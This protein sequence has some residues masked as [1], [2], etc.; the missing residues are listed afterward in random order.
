MAN[1]GEPITLKT[2]RAM[3]RA[4]APLS[5]H[6]LDYR[7]RRGK[8]IVS[9]LGERKGFAGVIR[10]KGK[11]VWIHAASVGEAAS[12][13]PLASRLLH[14]GKTDHV[15]LTTGT[16]TSARLVENRAVPG[17]IHQFS[18]LDIPKYVERFLGHWNPELAIFVESEL[19][20]NM[21]SGLREAGITTVLINGRLSENSAKRWTQV[22]STIKY[23]LHTFARFLVQTQS[24]ADRLEKLGADHVIVSGNLKYDSP[25]PSADPVQLQSLRSALNRRPIWAAIST[26]PGE[27]E[28]VADANE[29]AGRKIQ[30]L[31]SVIIP[32]HP[33]RGEQIARLLT[34]RGFSVC[35]RSEGILPD[36]KTDIYIADTLGEIGLFCR[37]ARLVFVGG[38]LVPHGGQ[39]PIEPIKLGAAVLHG[40][41]THNFTEIYDILAKSGALFVVTDPVEMAQG[42]VQLFQ[43]EKI[44]DDMVAQGREVIAGLTGALDRTLQTISPYLLEKG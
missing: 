34:D 37:L 44:R 39:N 17:I 11:M 23:L 13:L 35:R 28:L 9:R 31:L 32:R 1:A 19:W 29:I 24:D 26:H 41:H 38:S 14:D 33:E 5:S 2:Y 8:E 30:G 36:Q 15:L 21:L 22:P 6:L 7:V 25:P 20:P 27:D 42:V 18:P 4:L 40:P 12:V 16:V 3:T 43:S 10:P